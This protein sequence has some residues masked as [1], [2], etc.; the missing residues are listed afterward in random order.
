MARCSLETQAALLSAE[1]FRARVQ[2][3]EAGHGSTAVASQQLPVGGVHG[4]AAGVAEA[5][6]EADARA[7]LAV[8]VEPLNNGPY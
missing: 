2:I 1:R 4:E 8:L 6:V 5:V 3:V 7:E